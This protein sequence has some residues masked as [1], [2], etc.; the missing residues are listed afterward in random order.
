[1]E[2]SK[3]N[4]IVY[5][6]NSIQ[7]RIYTIRG[8][9]VMLDSDLAEVYGVETRRL[10]E[11]VKRN[12]DRF[13]KEF[14]FQLMKEEYENLMSQIAMSNIKNLKSQVA[15][16][17]SGHGGRRKSPYVF[18]EQGVA[19][20]SGVLKSETAVKTSIQ[21][22]NA[23]VE[24]RKFLMNN[25]LL[26]QRLD[27]VER[28]QLKFKIEANEK[29]DKIFNALQSKEIEPKQ[30]IFFNGQIFDAYKFVSGLIRKA[31][32]SILLIDNYIDETVLDLFTKKKKNVG[33]TIFTK[34]ITKALLLD[35]KKFNAQ[36]P[37][38]ELKKF[39][40]A[41]DR[42]LIIDDKDVYHFGASLKDLG[43]KWFAFSKFDKAAISLLENL[44]R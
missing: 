21:I 35:V 36:Y 30:G 34:R 6:S 19:M 17:R 4:I 7:Q 11:Q 38:I 24:M 3:N 13:P 32:K 1:M 22:M 41:H 5:N 12:I 25:A 27:N 42:F 33:V 8:V 16:S 15:I 23:F 26:F 18:T 29:F 39:T 9:Q 31:I 40:K 20:L 2:E 28:K 37:S 43:K 14:M 10:N 44:K